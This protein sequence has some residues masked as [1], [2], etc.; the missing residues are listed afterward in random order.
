MVPVLLPHSPAIAPRAGAAPRPGTVQRASSPGTVPPSP[1]GG[2]TSLPP[3]RTG[4][5]VRAT[6]RP[7][8]PG[9]RGARGA[10]LRAGVSGAPAAGVLR[11]PA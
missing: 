4:C 11:S 2:G 5:Q 9:V 7:P 3:L 6:Y 1:R 10:H 8:S